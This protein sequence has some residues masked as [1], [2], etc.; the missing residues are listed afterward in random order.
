MNAQSELSRERH[1][2]NK[3]K[4]N[5]EAEFEKA[6][7]LNK[8]KELELESYKK[9]L[10]EASDL[11]SQLRSEIKQRI[12]ESN[13]LKLGTLKRY[14]FHEFYSWRIKNILIFLKIV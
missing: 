1:N 14:L 7:M 2:W 9:Q 6:K 5:F 11:E 8:A 13:S 12:V 10:S 3:D 4:A